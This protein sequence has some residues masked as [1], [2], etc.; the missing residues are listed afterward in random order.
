M[1]SEIAGENYER[2]CIFK[3]IFLLGSTLYDEDMED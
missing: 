1:L 2:T 3:E